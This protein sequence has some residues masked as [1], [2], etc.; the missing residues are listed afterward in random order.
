[1][2][3]FSPSQVREAERDLGGRAEP[4]RRGGGRVATRRQ[5]SNPPP[6]TKG[7]HARGQVLRQGI[8]GKGFDGEVFIWIL[9]RTFENWT[10]EIGQLFFM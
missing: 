2:D 9:I 5:G 10:Q 3:I 1:M 8:R 7:L 4:G 6:P